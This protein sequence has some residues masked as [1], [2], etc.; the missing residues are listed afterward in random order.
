M[1]RKKR[2]VEQPAD[3]TQPATKLRNPMLSVNGLLKRI[4]TVDVEALAKKRRLLER[5]IEG[6]KTLE[7][8]ARRF[9]GLQEDRPAK[10]ATPP[11]A[12]IDGDG[13][14]DDLAD[15]IA[16]LLDDDQPRAARY[17]ATELGVTAVAINAV[18]ADDIRFEETPVGWKLI[19]SD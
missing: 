1:P 14:D 4:G 12:D 8:T 18:L 5:Q 2:E 9:Q 11:A 19:N 6:I 13:D 16:N 17:L 7:A 15:R 10:V 3:G